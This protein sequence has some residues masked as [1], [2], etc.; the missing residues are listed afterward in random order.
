MKPTPAQWSFLGLVR[1]LLAL[2]VVCHHI[3]GWE[4]FFGG[5]GAVLGFLFI[6]GFS[7]AASL[8]KEQDGFLWRRFARLVPVYLL[9]IGLAVLVDP[10]YR[11]AKGLGLALM[12]QTVA[13]DG[14]GGALT[15]A[16]S[17]AVE[18]WLYVSAKYLRYLP[19]VSWSSMG[20]YLA[21]MMSG[22]VVHHQILGVPVIL[23]GG[24]W[25]FGFRL[26]KGVQA[27][28]CWACAALCAASWFSKV[29]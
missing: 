1:F 16:W 15:P 27:W 28:E 7:I 24:F 13:F 11:G 29:C 22:V 20:L 23:L 2:V 21:A 10:S 4:G 8:E 5:N 25:V 18:W 17:L 9:A 6:S 26:Y 19:V 3:K 14:V 12:L